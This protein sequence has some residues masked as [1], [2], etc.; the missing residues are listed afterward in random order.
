MKNN[1]SWYTRN[2]HKHTHMPYVLILG[3]LSL[4]IDIMEKT[5]V[6]NQLDL[7]LIPKSTCYQLND[8]EQVILPIWAGPRW[9]WY[10]DDTWGAKFKEASMTLRISLNF[11]S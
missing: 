11:A 9:G 5:W 7:D 4:Q 10:K 6:Q 8:F 2:T 3:F 1:A